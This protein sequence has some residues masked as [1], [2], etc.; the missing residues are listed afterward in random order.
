MALLLRLAHLVASI[1]RAF[2][3][4]AGVTCLCLCLSVAGVVV[5]VVVL[6]FPPRLHFPS[7]P[8]I[9]L[10]F[11]PFTPCP[12]FAA[13]LE[14][15]AFIY[16]R[17]DPKVCNSRLHKR[18]RSEEGGVSLEYLQSI[19]DRHEEWL[20]ERAPSDGT[21]RNATQ[22]ALDHPFF[23]APFHCSGSITFFRLQRS[24]SASSDVCV[25][26][27][28]GVFLCVFVWHGGALD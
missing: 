9:S 2:H 12:S 5:V 7:L 23:S 4:P 6:V 28:C 22:S 24:A 15:D 16:L 13:E 17:V 25:V 14:V 21:Q 3:S 19:H 18:N 26:V 10:P 20:L 27:C 11:P 8:F 1:V